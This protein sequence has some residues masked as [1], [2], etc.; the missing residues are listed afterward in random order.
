M[1]IAYDEKG[2]KFEYTHE[3]DQKE[4]ISR[5]GYTPTDPNV[6]SS[7]ASGKPAN[8]KEKVAVVKA[9]GDRLDDLLLHLGIDSID[10]LTKED[11]PKVEQFI[12]GE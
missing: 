1:F 9:V 7:K 4:A 5:C 12:E 11:I 10:S 6:K 3:V 8:K 2:N